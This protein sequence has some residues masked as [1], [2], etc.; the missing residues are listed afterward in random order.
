MWRKCTEISTKNV[1]HFLMYRKNTRIFPARRAEIFPLFLPEILPTLF[2]ILPSVTT[3]NF[4][5]CHN[6]L[7]GLLYIIAHFTP[8]TIV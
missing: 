1:G 5:L 8:P 2:A 6:A 3:F 7:Y 4:S